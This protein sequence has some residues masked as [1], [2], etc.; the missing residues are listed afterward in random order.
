MSITRAKQ[1]EMVA[2]QKIKQL[3]REMDELRDTQRRAQQSPTTLDK[4]VRNDYFYREVNKLPKAGA[5]DGEDAGDR[6]SD[7]A[8]DA[9]D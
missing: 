9:M 3:H 1:Q 5:V 7:P 4:F 2:S 6:G 8:D